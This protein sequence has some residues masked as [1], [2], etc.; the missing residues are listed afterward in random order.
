MKSQVLIRIV[1]VSMCI[2]ALSLPGCERADQSG[3]TVKQASNA[4][5]PP[6]TATAP[7]TATKQVPTTAT[8][9]ADQDVATFVRDPVEAA[10]TAPPPQKPI[11]TV[12]IVKA[13]PPEVDL[14]DIPTNDSKAGKVRLVNTGDVPMTV[15]NARA[16][17]GCT[18]LKF[19]PNTVIAP[20]GE[21]EVDIQMTGGPKA[22]D[23]HG[24]SVT[25]VVE[26]QPEVVVPLK[27]RAVTFVLHEPAAIDPEKLVDGK[28]KLKAIDDQPFQIMSVQPP[29]VELSDANKT[30]AA[31][32]EITVSWDKYREEGVN[33]Q[34]VVYLDH[35]KCNQVFVNVSWKQEEL[36]E[37]VRRNQQK[38]QTNK[39]ALTSKQATPEM[40]KP[41]ADPDTL[42][43]EMIEQ[44]RNVEV[45]QRLQ[46]GLDPNYRDSSGNSLLGI[47]AKFGNIELM[48]SLIATGKV[49]INSTDNV[50]RTP[51]MHAGT[52][53]NVEAVRL[54][55]DNKADITTRD[56]LGTTALSWA[57]WLGDSAS[58]NELLEQGS[59]VEVVSTI[60]GWTPLMLAAAFGD[61][62]AVESLLKVHANVE[63]VDMLEGATP[64]IHAARTGQPQSLQMLI[65]AG[66]NLEIPDR[67][68]N[69]P[70][71]SCAKT[72]GGDADKLKILL[73]AGA[74]VKAKDNRG[75]NALE[76]A[77]K[78]T[79]ARAADVI[80]LLEPL[81]AGETPAAASGG[82]APAG[83]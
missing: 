31:E 48:K 36:L 28:I 62:G 7:D 17:C 8:T 51:L 55:I 76:L 5:P 78:R 43:A 16:S 79:D 44:G 6:A 10:K 45:M 57:A 9:K 37:A 15:L 70:L 65:K 75:L 29:V 12:Q 63:A 68:G 59:D 41:A 22:M 38:N 1:P 13:D 54:L 82:T 50:G 23:L 49:E 42:L 14:G 74:N 4:A 19:Q 64:L 60:T 77:R 67:N 61:P 33:R 58:V 34:L 81:L 11:S 3:A 46:T 26:G 35:P 80:K 40:P 69:T 24:K 18:A 25:F 56:N 53:K 30:K 21:I 20:K 27:A 72:S 71:L 66:A 39:D 32:Q 73:D 52:S 47:A 83:S 2:C